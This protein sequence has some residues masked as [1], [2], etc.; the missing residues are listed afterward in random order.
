LGQLG[1]LGL[2]RAAK[3]IGGRRTIRKI[4][5]LKTPQNSAK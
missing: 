2:A 5:Q 1:D 3:F 4:P